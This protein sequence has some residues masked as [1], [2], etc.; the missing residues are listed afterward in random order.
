MIGL[1][2]TKNITSIF[3]DHPRQAPESRSRSSLKGRYK[4][5]KGGGG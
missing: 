5:L 2:F 3:H 4:A 1:F